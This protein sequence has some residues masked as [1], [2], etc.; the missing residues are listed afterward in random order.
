[1]NLAD[2]KISEH[3]YL[4]WFTSLEETE[5]DLV[6][7]VLRFFDSAARV[8][9]M[10]ESEVHHD[11]PALYGVVRELRRLPCMNVL[12]HQHDGH[13]KVRGRVVQFVGVVVR[14]VMEQQGWVGTGHKAALGDPSFLQRAERYMPPEGYEDRDLWVEAHP[15]WGPRAQPSR[16]RPSEPDEDEGGRTRAQRMRDLI[17]D[18]R[19][20]TELLEAHFS[21]GTLRLWDLQVQNDDA[22]ARARV[23]V[24]PSDRSFKKVRSLIR[25]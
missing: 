6:R 18:A 16:T 24:Q 9:R 15:N 11:R 7:E 22:G 23:G 13:K 2:L 25:K 20:S 1:M 5:P 4:R 3:P 14:V 17:R 8:R 19:L 21:K 10:K 12:Q